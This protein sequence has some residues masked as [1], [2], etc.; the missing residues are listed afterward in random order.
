MIKRFFFLSGLLLGA[1]PGLFAD[2]AF[3]SRCQTQGMV[4]CQIQTPQEV[5][6]ATGMILCREHLQK[7][8][9]DSCVASAFDAALCGEA[10]TLI[11]Q[12]QIAPPPEAG[13]AAT[14]LFALPVVVLEK[15]SEGL[16]RLQEV[17]LDAAV[18]VKQEAAAAGETVQDAA[19][20]AAPAA[21]AAVQEAQAAGAQA[22]E[23]AVETGKD[24]AATAAATA[25]EAATATGE[26]ADKA[27]AATVEAADQTLEQAAQVGEKAGEALQQ[28]GE[29]MQQQGNE[30]MEKGG[31][32]FEK[33]EDYFEP[34]EPYPP[35]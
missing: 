14:P 19:A 30:M 25:Q 17:V 33:S 16:R 10:K 23:Q 7:A 24:A 13:A 11:L 34:A 9:G 6:L 29:A 8:L 18:E 28:A 21:E 3:C 35:Q 22:V 31:E 2:A 20:V 27:A 15:T 4:Q 5:D 12:P 32:A 26:A 1:A